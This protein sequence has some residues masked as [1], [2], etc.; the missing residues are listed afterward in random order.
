MGAYIRGNSPNASRK[1]MISGLLQRLDYE[2]FIS[3]R[4][5]E[6]TEDGIERFCGLEDP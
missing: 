5:C 3:G 4:N 1:R 6:N 2:G